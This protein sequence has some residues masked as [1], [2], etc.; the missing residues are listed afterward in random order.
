MKRL[1]MLF[2]VAAALWELLRYDALLTLG[3]F[4]R[5]RRILVP[6][7]RRGRQQDSDCRRVV[8]AMDT[9]SALYWKPVMCLQNAMVTAKLLRRSGFN[10][11]VVIGCRPE[12]FFSHAWVELDG[13]VVNDS[14]VYREQLPAL[15]RL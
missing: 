3:G 4:E 2:L 13:R 5:A 9:A 12:P 1:P 10:A 7:A 11:E 6:P 8:V 14:P 15:A